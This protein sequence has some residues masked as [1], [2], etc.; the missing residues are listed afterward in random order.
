MLFYRFDDYGVERNIVDFDDTFVL[1]DI[2]DVSIFINDG[3]GDIVRLKNTKNKFP[4]HGIGDIVRLKKQICAEYDFLCVWNN[5][6]FPIKHVEQ[7][8]KTSLERAMKDRIDKN[9]CWI[10]R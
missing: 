6:A 4:F 10:V 1:R 2:A 9:L 5:N 3:I 7:L 8:F